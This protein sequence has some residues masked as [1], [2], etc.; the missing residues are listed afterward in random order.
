MPVVTVR[1]YVEIESK[2]FAREILPVAVAEVIDAI[3]VVPTPIMIP[4]A[5]AIVAPVIPIKGA[6]SLVPL[7]ASPLGVGSR[8]ACVDMTAAVVLVCAPVIVI[9]PAAPI[10]TIT[11]APIISITATPIIIVAAAPII[12][13]TATPIVI[14]STASIV[15]IAAARRGAMGNRRTTLVGCR[16]RRRT[17]FGVV[18][19]RRVAGSAFISLWVA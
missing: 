2:S 6:P 18:N 11:A 5:P 13:I 4:V 9:A 17:L 16:A 1:K 14:V 3:M 15:V 7:L 19:R 8:I 10:I 12:G